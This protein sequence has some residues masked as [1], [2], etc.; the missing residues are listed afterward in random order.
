MLNIEY[1]SFGMSFNA[2]LNLCENSF[3]SGNKSFKDL[4][5]VTQS[6]EVPFGTSTPN[7]ASTVSKSLQNLG[8]KDTKSLA[9]YMN[10]P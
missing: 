3:P 8:E 6:D 2:V 10:H 5:I 1:A 4:Y 7:L 9:S